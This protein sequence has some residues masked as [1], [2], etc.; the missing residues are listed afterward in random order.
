[1]AGAAVVSELLGHTLRNWSGRRTPAHLVTLAILGEPVG[2]SLLTWII[3]AEQ[4]P[5]TAALGGAIIL[6]GIAVG[7]WRAPA[8]T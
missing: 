2:A 4:P 7:F 6:V 5:W 3:V 1:M 8:P